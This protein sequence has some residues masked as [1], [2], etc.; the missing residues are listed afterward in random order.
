MLMPFSIPQ[1]PWIIGVHLPE[2]DYL[3]DLKK[4]R[5]F[6]ILLTLAIS[7]AATIIALY[8]AR[9]IIRPI[10]NLE[11]EAL[12]VKNDDMQTQ[13]NINSKSTPALRQWQSRTVC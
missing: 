10:T 11:M 2:D 8:F 13:F 3:G 4:S 1:W 7:V 5:L 12:A 6:N 9:S